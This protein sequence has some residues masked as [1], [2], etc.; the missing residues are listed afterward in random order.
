MRAAYNSTIDYASALCTACG[1]PLDS[2][3]FD[4]SSVV[5]APNVGETI[6]LA[7]F[8]LPP[9][10]CGILEYFAQFTDAYERDNSQIETP[11][12]EWLILADGSPLFPYLTLKHIVNPWG[13]GAF[14]VA[15]RLQENTTLR[16]IARG[17]SDNSPSTITKIDNCPSTIKKIGGRLL[18]RF[19]FNAAHGDAAQRRF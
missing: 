2:Q 3:Y 19:W 17:V 13:N 7:E 15:I 16:F 4:E 1:A 5:C 14:P 12:I 6:V 11:G 9:Q 10:Y 8:G 18:G